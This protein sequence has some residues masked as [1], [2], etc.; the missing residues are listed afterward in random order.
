M[1]RLAICVAIGGVFLAARLVAHSASGAIYTTLGD[2]S[3]VNFNIY[4]A[5][6]DVHLNGGPGPGAPP[7]AAA[8]EDGDYVFQVTDPSGGTLLSEDLPECRQVTVIGG[9]FDN[10]NTSPA[11]LQASSRAVN[12]N[13]GYPVLSSVIPRTRERWCSAPPLAKPP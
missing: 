13:G 4:D 11:G 6:E 9:V 5:K 2:G 10:T 8:L 3:E 12:G 7:G 1:R